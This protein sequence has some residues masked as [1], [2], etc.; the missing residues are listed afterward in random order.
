[1]QIPDFPTSDPAVLL[2]RGLPGSGKTTLA[3]QWVAQAPE[4]RVRVNRD[5]LRAELFAAEGLLSVD[6][7]AEVTR[8]QRARVAAALGAGSSVVCD[9]THLN[10]RAID[11]WHEF[12]AEHGVPVVVVDVA[13]PVDECVRRDRARGAAGGRLVG[14]S[15]IR[16]IAS[17]AT[18]G[19]SASM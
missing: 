6:Q 15:V 16:M 12:L 14:E 19:D 10:E 5:D 7:E 17:R 1:M 8:V 4:R 2:T 18:A 3:L 11:A 9:D 13:T